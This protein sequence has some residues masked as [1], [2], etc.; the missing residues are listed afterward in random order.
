[1]SLQ[2]TPLDSSQKGREYQGSR[3]FPYLPAGGLKTTRSVEIGELKITPVSFP[4]SLQ[5]LTLPAH[6][7]TQ[8]LAYNHGLYLLPQGSRGL[9]LAV[10]SL[11]FVTR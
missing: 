10:R 4:D 6:D 7:I 11:S 8:E 2:A 1:M 9:V 3:P 5:I